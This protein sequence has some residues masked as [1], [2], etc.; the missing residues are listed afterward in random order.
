MTDHPDDK[1][2]TP[3]FD[4][5]CD[6]FTAY[7]STAAN[8]KDAYLGAAYSTRIKAA[9]ADMKFAISEA[10]KHP[11]IGGPRCDVQTVQDPDGYNGCY[12]QAIAA[13]NYLAQ[14]PRPAGGQS[15]FNAEHLL[16]IADEMKR[17]RPTSPVPSAQC[18]GSK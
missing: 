16:Q 15:Q 18:E 2:V 10:E 17:S 4:A 5:T 11:E 13:L 9:I 7:A 3:D 6:L 12:R 14:Y 1:T 8:W